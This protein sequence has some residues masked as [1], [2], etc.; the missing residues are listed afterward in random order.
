MALVCVA[1]VVMGAIQV[2]PMGDDVN[3]IVHTAAW[4]HAGLWFP[5]VGAGLTAV[6][7]WVQRRRWGRDTEARRY[8]ARHS[9]PA[10]LI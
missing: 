7:M 10:A 5:W 2:A 9:E 8:R 3:A 6:A 1:F 4:T